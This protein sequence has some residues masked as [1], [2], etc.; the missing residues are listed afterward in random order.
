MSAYASNSPVSRPSRTDAKVDA[1]FGGIQWS[2]AHG[3]IIASEDEM[4]PFRLPP[5][6]D[7]KPR[8]PFR[9]GG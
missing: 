1:D 3:F 9:M 4:L 8:R 6:R 7:R 2:D 5:S